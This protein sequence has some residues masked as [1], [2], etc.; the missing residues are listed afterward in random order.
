MKIQQAGTTWGLFL[1]EA[2][3]LQQSSSNIKS[4]YSTDPSKTNKNKVPIQNIHIHL[5][6]SKI[7]FLKAYENNTGCL[8]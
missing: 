1:K 4:Y 8:K 5:L 7:N 3:N 2:A 6:I